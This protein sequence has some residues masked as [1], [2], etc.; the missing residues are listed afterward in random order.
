[1]L[2]PNDESIQGLFQNLDR[3]WRKEIIYKFKPINKNEYENFALE[4]PDQIANH[5]IE[6]DNYIVTNGE[7][8]FTF[9]ASNNHSNIQDYY[10]ELCED[11]LTGR[12]YDCSLKNFKKSLKNELKLIYENYMNKM[13]DNN[14]IY[15]LN[16]RVKPRI[17][18]CSEH[19]NESLF[20][21][22]KDENIQGLLDAH[23][24]ELNETQ[25]DL[26]NEMIKFLKNPVP[27]TFKITY[28]LRDVDGCKYQR[29]IKLFHF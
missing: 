6:D 2:H 20:N 15:C 13:D 21:M 10:C 1:M 14:C 3:Y 26:Y 23:I 24:R 8:K 19:Y 28:T 18:F 12:C 29:T 22:L 9:R 27:R 17:P 4:L 7:L 25:L 11:D 16:P 5:F